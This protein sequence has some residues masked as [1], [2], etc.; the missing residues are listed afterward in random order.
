MSR[1]LR[2]ATVWG[3]WS[4]LAMGLWPATR[5]AAW[6]SMTFDLP[7][8]SKES[9]WRDALARRLGGRTEVVIEGG[10]VDVLTPTYAIEVEFPDKW[11]EGVGQALHYGNATR[12]QGMLA[13]IAYAQGEARLR[14]NSRKKLE[15]IEK[16]CIAS[17]IKMVVLYPSRPESFYPVLPKPMPPIKKAP[18]TAPRY[19]LNRNTP[20]SN[21]FLCRLTSDDGPP[22][23]VD[24]AAQ[25][26]DGNNANA[27]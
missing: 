15:M 25:A 6:E 13:I 26:T 19:W 10:R 8:G 20:S 24:L 12:R 22:Q 21:Y 11:H 18:S 5:C 14:E 4:L 17:R 2:L 1:H 16:Q 3:V 7:S 9:V 27:I 23:S